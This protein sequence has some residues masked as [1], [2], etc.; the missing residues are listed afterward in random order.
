M[1]APKRV[2]WAMTIAA[3][4]AISMTIAELAR[5]PPPGSGMLVAAKAAT[6]G[7][8]IGT[9][10]RLIMKQPPRSRNSP[11]RVTMNG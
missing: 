11:A 7:C 6:N 1:L 4:S 10:S 8:W 3:A 2:K 5:K 9:E